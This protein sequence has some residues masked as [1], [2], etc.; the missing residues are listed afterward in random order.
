LQRVQAIAGKEIS[1]PAR[2]CLDTADASSNTAFTCNQKEPNLSGVVHVRAAAQFIRDDVISFSNA[3]GAHLGA[4]FLAKKR[5]RAFIDGLFQGFHLNGQVIF[6]KDF[7][8]DPCF[9]FLKLILLH[10]HWVSEIKA[11]PI[12][13]HQRP[14]LPHLLTQQL[15][16]LGMQ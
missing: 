3:N 1:L 16:Q 8:V 12:R 4:V 2:N 11:Q 10:S 9:N 5:H 15:A 14:R 13:C 7:S 6:G